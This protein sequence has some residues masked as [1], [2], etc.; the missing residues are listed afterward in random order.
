MDLSVKE[1]IIVFA[2]LGSNSVT[3]PIFSWKYHKF[4]C[5]IFSL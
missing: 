1:W 5:L 3:I 2:I 4:D